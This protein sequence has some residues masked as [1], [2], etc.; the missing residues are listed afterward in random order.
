MA[1]EG[2]EG[3]ERATFGPV[4]RRQVDAWLDEHLRTQLGLALER[5]LFRSGRV[6]AVFG[7]R[8]QDGREVAVKVHRPGADLAHL[9]AAVRAQ[10]HLATHG[11]PCPRPLHGPTRVDGRV[12]GRVVVV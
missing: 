1:E 8:L 11:Y 4:P 5:V 2:V 9:G 6:S 3:I 10:H 12:D 7:C